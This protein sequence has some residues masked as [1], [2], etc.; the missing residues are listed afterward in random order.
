MIAISEAV[1]RVL[2]D[3]GNSEAKIS[4]IPHGVPDA[5]RG[6]RLV[7]RR[8]LGIAPEAFA[9]FNAARF[10][11]DKGQDVLLDMMETTPPF[12][13]PSTGGEFTCV[14]YLVGDTDTDFGREVQQRAVGMDGVHFMGYRDDVQRILPAFDVYVSGGRREAFGL[15]LVEA[16]AAG[17]PVVATDVGG[18][19]EVVADG[20]TGL[21]APSEDS[22]ALA[23]A[24]WKLRDDSLRA[25][26]GIAAR[27][28]Y[29]AR[30]TIAAMVERTEQVYRG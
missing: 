21:L 16:L 23:E 29:E 12:G 9:L 26:F 27:K 28:R 25:T 15:S 7:L 13:H 17:I 14:L 5:P 4:V 24:V 3:A 8:E 30:F 19:A 6:D 20:E 2:L 11:R 10:I 22:D 1:K 18:V